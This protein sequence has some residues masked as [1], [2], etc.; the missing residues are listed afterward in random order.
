MSY[1]EGM[2]KLHTTQPEAIHIITGIVTDICSY[3]GQAIDFR[4][5]H[6]FSYLARKVWATCAK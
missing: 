3:I 6:Q 2:K 5:M 4:Q 1:H